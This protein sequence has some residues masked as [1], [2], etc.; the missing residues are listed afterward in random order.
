MGK[1]TI[2]ICVKTNCYQNAHPNRELTLNSG[3]PA[4]LARFDKYLYILSWAMAAVV[5]DEK[6]PI[7]PG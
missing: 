1:M 5:A 7:A 2:P 3:C 6:N 4:F